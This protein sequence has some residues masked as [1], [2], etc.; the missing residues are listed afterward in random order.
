[1]PVNIHT[2]DAFEDTYQVLKDS[3]VGEYGGIIHNFN[4]DPEWLKS[5]L[6]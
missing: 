3:H 2:R 5:F 1:M 4:G 6:I